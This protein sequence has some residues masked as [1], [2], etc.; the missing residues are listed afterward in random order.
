[1]LTIISKYFLSESPAWHYV[2]KFP[3]LI[4]FLI[5]LTVLT[6]TYRVTLKHTNFKQIA[7]LSALVSL[8]C[9]VI[10]NTFAYIFRLCYSSGQ[11]YY[12]LTILFAVMIWMRTLILS[13]L[14]GA[15][16]CK[17][18]SKRSYHPVKIIKKAF[19]S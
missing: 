5:L 19:L 1:L 17:M 6:I 15:I 16:F 14:Y 13:V 12:G 7:A 18:C 10:S 8:S 3:S 11:K 2:L 4:S 9:I